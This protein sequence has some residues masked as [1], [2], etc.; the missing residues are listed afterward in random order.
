MVVSAKLFELTG[1]VTYRATADQVWV[2]L[3]SAVVSRAAGSVHLVLDGIEQGPD[4]KR[5]G[6]LCSY[7]TGVP[8]AALATLYGATKNA[9]YLAAAEKMADA[10]MRYFADSDGVARETACEGTGSC[11]CDGNEFRGPFVRGLSYLFQWNRDAGIGRFLNRTLTSALKADCNAQ[12]QFEE[13]GFSR[14]AWCGR[15]VSI[16]IAER[17]IHEY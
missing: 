3:Q 4:C 7:S 6:S 17:Y 9:T 10:G 14:G 15:S 16:S 1:E 8:V 11:G 2:W 12:W 13:L 5:R